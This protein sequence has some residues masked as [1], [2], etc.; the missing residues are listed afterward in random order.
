MVKEK[1]QCSHFESSYPTS[2]SS[3][4][5]FYNYQFRHLI[6]KSEC[7]HSQNGYLAKKL[8]KAGKQKYDRKLKSW[9]RFDNPRFNGP[10]TRESNHAKQRF[11]QRGRFSI[12]V[13]KD[14][15]NSTTIVVTYLPPR[16]YCV[17]DTAHATIRNQLDHM[18]K[19]AC[20]SSQWTN[21]RLPSNDAQIWNPTKRIVRE[22]AIQ[23]L[24]LVFEKD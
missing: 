6:Q 17:V 7:M 18:R 21:P 1:M 9:S 14:D 3:K 2:K 20:R 4:N 5:L 12:P 15:S 8:K 11:K 19:Y 13:Y 16:Q 22:R 24:W 23:K 10:Q